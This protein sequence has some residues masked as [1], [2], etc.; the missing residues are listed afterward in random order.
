[1]SPGAFLTTLPESWRRTVRLVDRLAPHDR[2]ARDRQRRLIRSVAS[3]PVSTSVRQ[4]TV[5]AGRGVPHHERRRP[6]RVEHAFLVAP[7]GP[8]AAPRVRR[9]RR[10][11]VDALRRV[12]VAHRRPHR[13][14]RI[15]LG[16][17]RVGPERQPD[18]DPGQRT[19]RVAGQGPLHARAAARTCRRSPPHNR[20]NAGCTLATTPKSTSCAMSALSSNSA[21]SMRCRPARSRSCPT[22]FSAAANPAKHRADRRVADRVEAALH[23]RAARSR[24]GARRP[25]RRSRTR[26]RTRPGS[27]A[28]HIG[29]SQVGGPGAERT[30]RVQVAGRAERAQ[31]PGLGRAA[32]L[33]QYPYTSGRPPSAGSA[34]SPVKSSSLDVPGP[35]H[36]CTAAI[37]SAAARRSAARWAAAPLRRPDRAHRLL[38]RHVVRVAAQPARRV[39]PGRA[40]AAGICRSSA[41]DTSAECTQARDRYTGRP[42]P[43]RSSSSAVG[44]V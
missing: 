11:H 14:P 34:S 10:P 40:R 3:G 12:A 32:E 21:C 8:P 27:V 28:V 30:V 37:P 15:Q 35:P 25:A 42:P 24:P 9:E 22:T 26:A 33:P 23:P 6:A 7:H 2:P 13:P 19:D 5:Q 39:E 20:S 43:A 31:L 38:P 44:S 18:P 36:S 17:R 41:E 16:D 1:M 4:R 29:L